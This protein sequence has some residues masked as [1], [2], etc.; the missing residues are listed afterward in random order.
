MADFKG[1][2]PRDC[3]FMIFYFIEDFSSLFALYFF[4]KFH[5]TKN[6][7]QYMSI[8]SVTIRQ[9]YTG[10]GIR[11]N[12]GP[13]THL[14]KLVGKINYV[15]DTES[16]RYWVFD[17]NDAT[18]HIRIQK[19]MCVT[20]AINSLEDRIIREEDEKLKPFPLPLPPWNDNTYM[21]VIGE[22]NTDVVDIV[23]MRPVTDFN[24]LTMHNL[25]CVYQYCLQ[26][27]K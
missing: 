18:G 16:T 13:S 9:L 11:S 27:E 17:F 19:K 15:S 26:S 25:E 24:E 4:E 10:E 22:M 23:D 7:I 14:V 5:N 2:D 3:I 21:V 12:S 20:Y 6:I 8:R 1:D